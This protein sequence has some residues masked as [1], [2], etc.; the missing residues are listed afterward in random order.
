MR[1]FI[2]TESQIRSILGEEFDTYLDTNSEDIP[3]K[4]NKVSVEPFDPDIKDIGDDA[5]KTDTDKITR[6]LTS[7]FS[8]HTKRGMFEGVKKKSLNERNQELD[9]L[10]ATNT[11]GKKTNDTIDNLA[12]RNPNDKLLNNMSN[13]KGMT[14]N[15]MSVRRH[16]LKNMKKQ[17]PERYANIGGKQLEKALDTSIKTKQNGVS[18]KKNALKN[19]GYTNVFQK[20]GQTKNGNGKAHTDKNP[21][22]SSIT[23]EY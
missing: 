5:I 7:K 10:G 6:S 12:S 18:A 19:A 17:D 16:R 15:A 20:E 1:K 4:L 23:F 9:S 22:F 8:P 2:F 3:N 13:E 11:L 21:N 14:Y